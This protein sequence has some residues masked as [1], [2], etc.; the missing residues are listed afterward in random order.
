[1]AEQTEPKVEPQAP[2]KAEPKVETVVEP[3]VEAKLA[4]SGLDALT[5]VQLQ[6]L[7]K[8]SPEMF[9]EAGITKKVEE[10]P[11]EKKVEPPPE[12]QKSAAPMLDGQEIKLPTDVPVN[13]ESVDEYLKHAQEIGLNANQVQAEI[14][15]QTKVAREAMASAVSSQLRVRARIANSSSNDQRRARASTAR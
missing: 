1:M 11:P 12:P 9:E 13:R 8:K 2:A 5:S 15:F 6:E 4:P 7:Y 10:K 3:K 14:N